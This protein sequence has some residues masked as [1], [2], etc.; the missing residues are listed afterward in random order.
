MASRL[1]DV[2]AYPCTRC[3]LLAPRCSHV[4]LGW[5][6]VLYYFNNMYCDHIVCSHLLDLVCCMHSLTWNKLATILH[7]V[8]NGFFFC[9]FLK[10]IFKYWRI[11]YTNSLHYTDI[12]WA[13][14]R[15]R[16]PAIA[17]LV[18]RLFRVTSNKTSLVTELFYGDPPIRWSVDSHHKGSITR[19]AFP[20]RDVIM[21]LPIHSQHHKQKSSAIDKD[22]G[23]RSTYLCN[24]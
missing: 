12:T 16:S 9:F 5:M 20:F 2:I 18:H 6:C 8:S 15:F 7:T 17:C 1:W 11:N 24:A 19:K 21:K 4:T 3:R 13:S 14:W 22:V 23:V 10:K